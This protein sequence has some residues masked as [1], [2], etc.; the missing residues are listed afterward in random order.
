MEINNSKEELGYRHS[1]S[2]Y[3]IEPSQTATQQGSWSADAASAVAEIGRRPRACPNPPPDT[4]P[5]R[6]IPGANTSALTG[7]GAVPLSDEWGAI[8]N[9]AQQRFSRG[10][11]VWGAYRGHCGSGDSSPVAPS[12]LDT[13]GARRSKC[14][15]APR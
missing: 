5:R 13:R 11:A 10:V 1:L 6:G 9:G 3:A 7:R 12:L 15:G 14:P 4:A 8:R 2:V